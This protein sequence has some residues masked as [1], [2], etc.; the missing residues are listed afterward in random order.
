MKEAL[1]QIR[2]QALSDLAAAGDEAAVEGLRLRYLGRKGELTLAMRGLREV[3]AEQRPGVGALLNQIKDE[4]E[5]RIGDALAA[6]RANVR[7]ARAS[8]RIDVTEPGR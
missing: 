7:A 4:I 8:E 6:S 5:A 3:P 1:E 2:A